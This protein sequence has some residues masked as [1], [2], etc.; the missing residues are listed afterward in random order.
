MRKEGEGL[1]MKNVGKRGQMGQLL[2]RILARGDS[3]RSV[4]DIALIGA[5]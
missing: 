3:I 1:S 5:S 4:I 2:L